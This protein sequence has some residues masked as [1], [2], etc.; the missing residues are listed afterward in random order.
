MTE[1]PFAEVHMTLF[2]GGKQ[3]RTRRI[4]IQQAEHAERGLIWL[5]LKRTVHAI[6]KEIILRVNGEWDTKYDRA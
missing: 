3:I 6:T 2:M 5:S 4:V 1:P